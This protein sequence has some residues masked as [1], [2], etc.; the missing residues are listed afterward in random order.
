MKEIIKK[1]IER[2]KNEKLRPLPKWRFALMDALYWV[3][4]VLAVLFSA[5]AVAVGGYLLFQIDWEALQ[6]MQGGSVGIFFLYVPY[7]WFAILAVLL[8]AVFYFIRK[9]KEGY[10]YRWIVILLSS[11]SL[12]LALGT[13]AHFARIGRLADEFAYRRIPMYGNFTPGMERMWQRSADGFLAGTIDSVGNGKIAVI[14]LDGKKWEVIVSKNTSIYGPVGIKNG[15]FVKIIGKDQG[16]NIFQSDAIIS[17]GGMMRG[18]DGSGMHG[19]GM[20]RGPGWR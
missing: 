14:G 7:I 6:Y 9:T 15:S 10:K 1:T 18:F 20:M 2:L 8:A 13:V 11:L 16:E 17:G 4:V 12:V 3:L 19:G 5:I